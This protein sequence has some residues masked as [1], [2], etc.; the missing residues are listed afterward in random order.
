ML[1]KPSI[2]L[3]QHASML[4]QD[5]KQ[6]IYPDLSL[7]LVI[8]QLFPFPNNPTRY[9]YIPDPFMLFGFQ[10]SLFEKVVS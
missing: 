7:Q 8:L 1:L 10:N 9:Q 4:F 5:Y 6:L 3:I 2:M